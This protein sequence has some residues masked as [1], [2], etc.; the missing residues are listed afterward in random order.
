MSASGRDPREAEAERLGPG[1]PIEPSGLRGAPG[2]GDDRLRAV[3]PP[4]R[5]DV[6]S[7]AVA[8]LAGL[9]ASIVSG[10]VLCVAGVALAALTL[11]AFWRYDA[12]E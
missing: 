6:E 5:L 10:G 1:P 2:P 8:S 12:R 3:A 4:E 9:R 11:P 7:G